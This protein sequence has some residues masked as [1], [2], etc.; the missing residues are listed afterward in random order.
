VESRQLAPKDRLVLY[1]DG[2]TEAQN[3]A[4]EFFGRTRLREAIARAG[5]LDCSGMH[6]AI[7]QSLR[8]FTGGAEQSDDVTLVVVSYGD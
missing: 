1:S 3:P 6:E 4:G 2:V 7:V 5:G 8:D